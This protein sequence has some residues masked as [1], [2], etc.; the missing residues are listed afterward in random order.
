MAL[1]RSNRITIIAAAAA[2]LANAAEQGRN[3]RFHLS[4]QPLRLRARADRLAE[5]DPATT[6]QTLRQPDGVEMRPTFKYARQSGKYRFI[7]TEDYGFQTGL[8]IGY[9]VFH[10]WFRLHHDGLLIL[11][12]GYAW[13]GATC[14]P[15]IASIIRGSAVHDCICQLTNNNLIKPRYRKHGDDLLLKCCL[16]DG[17]LPL[18]AGAVYGAVRGWTA[19]KTI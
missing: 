7:V 16:E 11:K 13:D 6:L 4:V 18:L 10:P 8:K 2:P 14:F 1:S 9:D 12:D 17:M 5:I 3:E 19:I 15:D